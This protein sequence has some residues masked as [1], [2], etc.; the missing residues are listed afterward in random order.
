MPIIGAHVSA[1]GGVSNTIERGKKIAA[2]AIMFFGAS[3]RQFAVKGPDEAEVKKFKDAYKKS[4]FKAAFMH[5]PYVVN[6]V[7]EK[8]SSRNVSRGI[9]AKH[10]EIATNLGINGLIFHVGSAKDG[11]RKEALQHAIEGI[12]NILSRVP[13][14]KTHLI[15]ESASGGG[16]IGTHAEDMGVIMKAVKSDRLKICID[17]AHSFEAGLLEYTKEGVKKF[18]DAWEKQVGK[19][20]IVVLHSNDSMTEFGSLHDRHENIGKGYIGIK[21]FQELAKDSRVKKL[22]W[23]LEVP[24]YDN[25]GPDKKN[26]LILRKAVK[27][28]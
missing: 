9:L 2:S 24:G 23:I 10:Y 7:S 27:G 11:D 25:N 12:K 4:G 28:E 19:N 14:S 20:G 6:L 5:G 16:K 18:F 8:E 26:V 13:K 15:M 17:T 21:G 3:P 22:P 1:A